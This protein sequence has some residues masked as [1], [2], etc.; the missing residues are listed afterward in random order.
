M[1]VLSRKPGERI[2][3]PQCGLVLTI[4]TVKGKAVRLGI[5][6]PADVAVLR[7]ELIRQGKPSIQAK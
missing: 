3:V 4:I 5:D 6:A 7:A 1:L 2:L